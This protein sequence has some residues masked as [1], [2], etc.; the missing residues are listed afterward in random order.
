MTTETNAV[1]AETV[2]NLIRAREIVTSTT[3]YALE[4]TKRLLDELDHQKKVAAT[5][6][7]LATNNTS[8]Y[9]NLFTTLEEFIKEHV[10]D[11]QV[12][13]DDLKELA[14][15]LDIALTKSIKVTFNVK[16]EYE[17]DVAIDF[18]TDDITEHDFNIRI[19]SNLDGDDVEETSESFEVED[20]EVEDND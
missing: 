9:L 11:E 1:L 8:R 17:F 10:K 15:E 12:S 20:L 18:D 6:K 2:D 19:S 13:I 14:E 7:Q 3:A 5:Q 16:C 4:E